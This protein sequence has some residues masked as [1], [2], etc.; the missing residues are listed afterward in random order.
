MYLLFYSQLGKLSIKLIKQIEKLNLQNKYNFIDIT[1]VSKE[2]YPELVGKAIPIIMNETK[3]IIISGDKTLEF[4]NNNNFFNQETNNLDFWKNGLPK[5]SI[6]NDKLAFN[7][8]YEKNKK[9]LELKD[10]LNNI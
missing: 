5:P 10:K 4:I 7:E 1:S 3:D 2:Q 9:L 6:P 8:D